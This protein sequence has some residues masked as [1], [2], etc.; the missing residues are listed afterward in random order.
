LLELIIAITLA[1]LIMILAFSAMRLAMRSWTTVESVGTTVEELGVVEGFLRRQLAQARRVTR[2]SETDQ[3]TSLLGSAR[4]LNFIAPMPGRQLGV[5][6]LYQ[7]LLQFVRADTGI[8]LQIT[9]W[10]DLPP[11]E[12]GP[13]AW[14]DQTRTLLKDLAAGEFA[15]YGKLDPDE[16]AAWHDEWQSDA[17]LPQL[18][19]IRLYS[20]H[21][22]TQ[23]P[24]LIIAIQAQ[25]SG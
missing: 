5:W 18:V 15:Y 19:R 23:W 12:A 2:S 9:Y 25:G 20:N 22:Q 8:D 24:E 10:L 3:N 7:C 1:G 11:T 13:A 14:K 4:S 17:S 6:G 16:P 21:Q